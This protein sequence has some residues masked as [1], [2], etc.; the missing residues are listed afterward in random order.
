MSTIRYQPLQ[1]AQIAEHLE[2][3]AALR[4]TVFREWPYLYEGSMD[5]ERR[6]LDTYVRCHDSLAVL[7]W[8]G[9]TCV[10]ATTALPMHHAEQAMRLPFELAQIN[11]DQWLYFGESVVLD[12]HRGRGIGVAFFEHREA[13]ARALGLKGCA[14]CAVD[15]PEHHPL[16]PSGYQGNDAFWTRRGYSRRPDL[17]CTF[18]WLDRGD[19]APSPHQLTYWLREL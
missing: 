9:D 2:A 13:H 6:Y 14:F 15:R 18:D 17:S 4:L 1:G 7:A 12:S 10:G 11:F 8:D 3:L 5:Y 19:S 16:R